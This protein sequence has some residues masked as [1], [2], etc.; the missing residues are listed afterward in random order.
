MKVNAFYS[1]SLSE[2][3]NVI[4]KDAVFI[5]RIKFYG[6]YISLYVLDKSF[7]EVYYN[8]YSHKFEEAELL[9]AKD[10]RLH[11]FAANVELNDLFKI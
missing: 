10:E 2:R 9:D 11:L 4:H 3:L 1:L 8:I 7:V 6:F 5:T